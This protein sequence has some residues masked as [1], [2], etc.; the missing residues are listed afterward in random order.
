MT[1][2]SWKKKRV[3]VVQGQRGLGNRKNICPKC[4]AKP[5]QSCTRPIGGRVCGEDIG[6]GYERTLK[7]VHPERRAVSKEDD[8]ECSDGATV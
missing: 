7:H 3:V 1:Q 5:G 6:G 2:I 8:D 4:G